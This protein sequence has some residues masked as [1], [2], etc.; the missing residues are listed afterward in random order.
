MASTSWVLGPVAIRPETHSAK[1][2]KEKEKKE[3]KAQREAKDTIR[4]TDRDGGME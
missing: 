4:Q 3:R 2:E 1:K